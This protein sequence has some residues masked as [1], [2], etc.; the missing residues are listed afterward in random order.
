MPTLDEILGQDLGAE[1]PSMNKEASQNNDDNAVDEIEKLAMEFGLAEEGE[2]D[3]TADNHQPNQ[4]H[5]KEANMGLGNLY[6]NMFPEDTQ[7]SVVAEKTASIDKEAAQVE[8][9]MG[10]AAYD[11]FQTK[12]AQIIEKIAE[13][14]IAAGEAVDAEAAQAL[15][16]NRQGKSGEKMDTTPQVTNELPAENGPAVVGQ[17]QQKSAA[18]RKHLLLSQV[19]A[20]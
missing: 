14:K 16:N 18:Y 10:K 3:P 6:D 4:G 11:A 8:E 7:E 20:E 19:E 9:A 5:T 12:V 17:E 1:Q 2:T 15:D 13:E